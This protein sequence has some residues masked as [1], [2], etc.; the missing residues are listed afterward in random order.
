MQ[1]LT[2]LTIDRYQI[3][4]QIGYGGMATVY[5][6]L[7]I[8]LE[9]YVA[10]KIIRLDNL[11]SEVLKRALKRFQNEAKILARLAHPNIVKV[12]DYGVYQEN[13]YL[14]MEYIPGGTL[15]QAMEGKTF[16]SLEAARLLIPIARAL[17]YAHDQG[18]IHRDIKPSN[19]LITESGEPMLTDFGVAKVFDNDLT[20]DLTAIGIG[21]GTPAYMAPEQGLGEKLDKRADIYSL[22]IVFYELVSGKQ[23]YQAETP[24]AVVLKKIND[25]LPDIKTYVPGI[26][27]SVEAIVYK[28]IAKNPDDRYGNCTELVTALEKIE[29]TPAYEKKYSVR[30]LVI[31]GIIVA[32]L[33]I[34]F[35]VNQV[36]KQG[37][38]SKPVNIPEVQTLEQNPTES[39]SSTQTPMP[40]NP[41]SIDGS[42]NEGA[43]L[44]FEEFNDTKVNIYG[45]NQ[46]QG[47]WK[48]V[49][50]EAGGKV[51]QVD[52]RAGDKYAG[53][54]FGDASWEDYSIEYRL[55][56][57]NNLGSLGLQVHIDNGYADIISQIPTGEV[58]LFTQTPAEWKRVTLKYPPIKANE[59]YQ[60]K[61][62]A[63]K[64]SIKYYVNNRL[65]IDEQ[66]STKKGELMFFADPGTFAQIDDLI[67]TELK[68][69][70]KSHPTSSQILIDQS[71]QSF[72]AD[73]E[74][75]AQ[76]QKK[77]PDAINI[78]PMYQGLSDKYS[79]QLFTD[80]TISQE[81]IS[82]S[83]V[84]LLPN[85]CGL[86]NSSEIEA[87]THYVNKGNGLLIFGSCGSSNILI[88]NL[89]L[90]IEYKGGPIGV[91][92]HLGWGPWGF[93]VHVNSSDPIFDGVNQVTINA[94]SVLSVSNS[95]QAIL[96]SDPSSWIDSNENQLKDNGEI[97]GSF[98]LI[99]KS[100]V[101]NGRIVIMPSES[102]WGGF[103]QDNQILI[104]NIIK[105][106]IKKY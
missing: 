71:H 33:F 14:V 23:P 92:D 39:N 41:S 4:E 74:V 18:L 5:K 16:S 76:E 11:E 104:D 10:V 89:G 94:G 96:F 87:I 17:N 60:I 93:K 9:C 43:L 59:W 24:M 21:L 72:I 6:A 31:P 65:W 105:W 66:S 82:N 1:S 77:N 20:Q 58:I 25:P 3:L 103:Y 64:D 55:K 78:V 79:V 36:T 30:W 95:E 97:I 91:N 37:L 27:P 90:G 85:T 86:F 63:D 106:L 67:V 100:E 101:G 44:V 29:A 40:N 88:N 12:T 73:P 84:L 62:I 68:T 49:Q 42:T 7:D 26:T 15:K 34:L 57:L 46:D 28:A 47:K 61:I 32:I 45:F 81:N 38:S 52:N 70:T 83:L 98:P 19:I 50:D 75:A 51:F 53:F 102:V 54:S 35:L 99:I 8:R 22:G 13:P 56:F 69:D 48:V 2:G 80:P